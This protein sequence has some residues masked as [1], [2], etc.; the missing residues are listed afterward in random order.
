MNRR[1]FLGTAGGLVVATMSGCAMFETRRLWTADVG[2]AGAPTVEDG[3]VYVGTGEAVYALDAENG[4]V[5]WTYRET[6]EEV[7]RS[8]AVSDGT[9]FVGVNHGA[10]HAIEDGEEYWVFD[11]PTNEAGRPVVVGSTVYVNDVA[12][13]DGIVYVPDAD[14]R[15][16]AAVDGTEGSLWW[17]RETGAIST[18]VIH[19]KTLYASEPQS[20]GVWAYSLDGDKQWSTFTTVDDPDAG[21][22]TPAVGGGRVFATNFSIERLYAFDAT[23]GEEKWW[24]DVDAPRMYPATAEGRVFVPTSDGLGAYRA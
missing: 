8:P 23:T 9:V 2:M 18:P 20:T 4:D 19:G 7:N 5:Q 3:A 14:T 24:E 1:R 11:A 12:C 6:N 16:L 21:M 22:S 13:T 15:R 17:E 10:V